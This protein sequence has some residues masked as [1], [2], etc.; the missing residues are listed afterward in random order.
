MDALVVSSEFILPNACSHLR[1]FTAVQL[2]HR[3]LSPTSHRTEFVPSAAHN[4]L[5]RTSG[6]SSSSEWGSLL[7]LHSRRGAQVPSDVEEEVLEALGGSVLGYYYCVPDWLTHSIVESSRANAS[8]SAWPSVISVEVTAKR[9]RV[10]RKVTCSQCKL[11]YWQGTVCAHAKSIF[12]PTAVQSFVM[13]PADGTSAIGIVG[14]EHMRRVPV[15]GWH[16]VATQSF[17]SHVQNSDAHWTEQARLV[18]NSTASIERA[19]CIGDRFNPDECV[20]CIEGSTEKGRHT[21]KCPACG[22]HEVDDSWNTPI[23]KAG[24]LITSTTMLYGVQSTSYRCRSC[25][26]LLV[27][28]CYDD[29]VFSLD[30]ALMA[31]FKWLYEVSES[32]FAHGT[33]YRA[34][35]KQLLRRQLSLVDIPTQ[36]SSVQPL[37]PKRGELCRL[38]SRWQSLMTIGA[39]C[40]EC[41][42]CG[43][44]NKVPV[45]LCD[46][47]CYGS[48]KELS[49]L[50]CFDVSKRIV[51]QGGCGT[52]Q[53]PAAPPMLDS[54]VLLSRHPSRPSVSASAKRI[55]TV[56][57]TRDLIIL[58]VRHGHLRPQNPSQAAKAASYGIESFSKRKMLKGCQAYFPW[59][60]PLLSEA[61]AEGRTR[62]VAES[63]VSAGKAVRKRSRPRVACASAPHCRFISACLSNTVMPLL[64]GSRDCHFCEAGTSDFGVGSLVK[65]CEALK[66]GADQP[67]ENEHV[68]ISMR[69]LVH[70][71]EHSPATAGIIA[72]YAGLRIEACA[73][74]PEQAP[75]IS[76]TVKAATCLFP[77]LSH[78]VSLVTAA[79][80]AIDKLVTPLPPPE[81][82]PRYIDREHGHT[83]HPQLTRWRPA[84]L[85]KS[86][87]GT[88]STAV[89]V[90][91]AT[92]QASCTKRYLNHKLFT[93]GFFTIS[94]PCGV[95]YGVSLMSDSESVAVPFQI[96]S[97]RFDKRT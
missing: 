96:F 66:V 15:V 14:T 79:T 91:Q 27:P 81:S 8:K 68:W 40:F 75:K 49:V 44:P 73:Q 90:I 5:Q 28:D 1:M 94:C 41:Q 76:I 84:M 33:T 42:K 82:I 43:P 78:V 93:A 92:Q 70:L 26:F 16:P 88:A 47:C 71:R 83:Y 38:W 39:E 2:H 4:M 89:Q 12:G 95:V 31:T 61:A 23:T 62:T 32:L 86:K 58:F 30:G 37:I 57:V 53:P 48:L 59:L 72:C 60:Y 9:R 10:T 54:T 7:Y 80:T 20:G 74:V 29:G 25:G 87:E 67:R 24:T 50:R 51:E 35:A 55:P 97:H 85:L 45:F 65:V 52:A 3:A 63:S 21:C 17:R 56:K 18:A 19:V 22:F 6:T 77:A 34:L 36:Q 46:G 64:V 11:P 69:D 13:Q